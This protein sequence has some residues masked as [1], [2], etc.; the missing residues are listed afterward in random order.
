MIWFLGELQEEPGVESE[1]ARERE[2]PAAAQEPGE[3]PQGRERGRQEALPGER[4]WHETHTNFI[5]HIVGFIY[6]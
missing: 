6:V 1:A 4:R 5:T 3:P 2:S